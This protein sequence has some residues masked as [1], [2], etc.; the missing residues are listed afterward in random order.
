[1]KLFKQMM[2]SVISLEAIQ[3]RLLRV[4]HIKA[5][6]EVKSQVTIEVNCKPDKQEKLNWNR[7]S[8]NRN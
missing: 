6:N 5:S 1:M 8:K 7:K 2:L 3:K 4:A